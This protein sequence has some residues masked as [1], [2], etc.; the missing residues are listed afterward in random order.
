M[1]RSPMLA[2]AALFLPGIGAKPTAV[3][4]RPINAAV[5]ATAA[6]PGLHLPKFLKIK[7][8][9]GVEVEMNSMK[10]RLRDLVVQE[11]AYY[12]QN[13]TYT[14][15]VKLVSGVTLGDSTAN[16]VQIVARRGQRSQRKR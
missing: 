10:T 14:R 2:A 16:G 5:V 12:A 8:K 3:A 4:D 15:N 11:E 9:R 13:K 6:F 1:I 7:R